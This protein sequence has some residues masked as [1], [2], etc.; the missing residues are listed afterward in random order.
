MRL[1]A[2]R[3]GGARKRFPGLVEEFV[4]RTVG[5]AVTVAA[6][7]A[8]LVTASVPASAGRPERGAVVSGTYSSGSAQTWQPLPSA[9]V[10]NDRGTTPD[11]TVVVDPSTL[12]QKYSGVG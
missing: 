2:P 1:P 7:G 10:G 9:Y 3:V 12:R 5:V 6:L 4:R 8:G 11:A